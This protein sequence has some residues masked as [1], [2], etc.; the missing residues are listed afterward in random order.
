M[1]RTSLYAA[2]FALSISATAAPTPVEIGEW[3]TESSRWAT[4]AETNPNIV[5]VEGVP[6]DA[7]TVNVCGIV[8]NNVARPIYSMYVQCNPSS[9]TSGKVK[10]V[11]SSSMGNTTRLEPL[12]PKPRRVAVIK[13]SAETIDYF[14]PT[15][16][17]SQFPDYSTFSQ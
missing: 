6:T 11:I 13:I 10:I 9:L 2:L 17:T 3:N 7:L 15:G 1:K 14:V 12:K 4:L 16:I 5:Y 8:F